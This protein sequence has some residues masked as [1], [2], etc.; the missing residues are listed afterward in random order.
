MQ[1]KLKH[2]VLEWIVDALLPYNT[3]ENGAFLRLLKA[4]CPSFAV[5]SAT[6]LSGYV[7][8]AGY[9]Q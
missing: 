5:P 8:D 1:R 3:V 7:L 4:A 2:L 6:Y 9:L